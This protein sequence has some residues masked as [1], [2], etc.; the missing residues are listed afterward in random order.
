MVA[1]SES[2]VSIKAGPLANADRLAEKHC[3]QYDKNAEFVGS[4][5]FPL[6]HKAFG[7]GELRRCMAH[8]FTMI[9][10]QG[11]KWLTLLET[12]PTRIPFNSLNPRLP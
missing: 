3:Q 9:Q 7:F 11:A 2:A 10:V 8:H 12:L 1:G 6:S 4:Q 5:P